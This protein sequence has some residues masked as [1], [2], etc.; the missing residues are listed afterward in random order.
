MYTFYLEHRGCMFL[1]LSLGQSVFRAV[2]QAQAQSWGKGLWGS[3]TAQVCKEDGENTVGELRGKLENCRTGDAKKTLKQERRVS[4]QRL[5]KKPKQGCNGDEKESR[6]VCLEEQKKKNMA[7]RADLVFPF[8]SLKS[9]PC[10][11][12]SDQHWKNPAW[13]HLVLRHS[14]TAS[15]ACFWLFMPLTW[16]WPHLGP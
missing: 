2:W 12:D 5:G 13:K 9:S 3:K 10:C 6:F 7:D 1:L 11:C 16:Q 8:D 4:E 14:V 15:P